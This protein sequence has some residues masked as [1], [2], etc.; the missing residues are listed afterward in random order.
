LIHIQ[1]NQ[2]V[3]LLNNAGLG[4]DKEALNEDIHWS[5][6]RGLQQMI[7]SL[8]DTTDLR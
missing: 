6:S 5:F 3:A 1:P 2:V 7:A 8:H 4:E